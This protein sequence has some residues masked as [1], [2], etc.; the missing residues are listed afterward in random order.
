M[1]PVDSS[2][3]DTGAQATIMSPRSDLFPAEIF[4]SIASLLDVMSI[5]RLSQ[6]SKFLYELLMS[7]RS[8]WIGIVEKQ[9][10]LDDL[11]P[12]S[13][14]TA[15]LPLP[16]I[17]ARAIHPHR[18]LKMI[19]A[20]SQQTPSIALQEPAR[21]GL[22]LSTLNGKQLGGGIFRR[23]LPGGRWFIACFEHLKRVRLVCWDL[24]T[25]LPGE[26]SSPVA[27][28]DACSMCA[29]GWYRQTMVQLQDSRTC[30]KIAV[31]YTP[32]ELPHTIWVEI[33]TISW[34]I[35]SNPTIT[36][37]GAFH[38]Y[39]TGIHRRAPNILL[40]GDLL[41]ARAV[42]SAEIIDWKNGGY[43]RVEM[44]DTVSQVMAILW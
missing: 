40:D 44:P 41:L 9:A 27:A 8:L 35:H 30:V 38:I 7:S 2:Q 4:L 1:P 12:H 3:I 18:L 6:V 28:A 43:I 23:L 31:P 15:D 20:P 34:K 26:V 39:R 16:Q 10:T 11:A 25:C 13:F 17:I 33:F 29:V 21:I 36:S 22:A 24:S 37:N 5:I 32:K 19:N 14:P 42:D